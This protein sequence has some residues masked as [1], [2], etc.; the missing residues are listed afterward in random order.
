MKVTLR[1][2][3]NSRG[4]IIPS[5][6]LEEAGL[7]KEVEMNLKDN[8]LVIERVKDE[9]RKGWFDQ[10]QVN[11]DYDAWQGFVEAD[12]DDEDWTW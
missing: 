11:N 1:N 8:V 3:G 5:S 7:D 9:V 10:Y 4:V 6:F 2:I 12:V